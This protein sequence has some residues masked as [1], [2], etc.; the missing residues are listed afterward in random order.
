MGIGLALAILVDATIVRTL[1]VPAT[2]R[3]L[4][5]YNWWAPRPLAALYARLG[6]GEREDERPAR[7]EEPALSG[8]KGRMIGDE[9]RPATVK[10]EANK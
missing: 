8:A 4:G 10:V 3:V 9:G 1:L 7:D 5:R 6:L 2:M